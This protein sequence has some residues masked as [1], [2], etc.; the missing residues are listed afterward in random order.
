MSRPASGNPAQPDTWTWPEERWRP[1]VEKVRAGRSLKPV[2]WPRGARCAV[3]LSFDSDHETLTRRWGDG[4]PGKL[5]QGE[6]GARAAV[7]RI[8]KLLERYDVPATFF[9]PAVVAMLYPDEQRAV[10]A[11]GQEIG[12]H[13]RGRRRMGFAGGWTSTVGD[14]VVPRI[15]DGQHSHRLLEIDELGVQAQVAAAGGVEVVEP[16][17]RVGEHEAAG[18]V[19][20]AGLP[21]DLL[22]LLVD[23]QRVVLELG[24]VGVGVEGVHAAG[25]VPGGAGGELGALQQDERPV[26]RAGAPADVV[27]P[28]LSADAEQVELDGALLIERFGLKA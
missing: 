27:S 6:Y 21:G 23:L 28:V 19:D 11:G 7:P 12:I 24:D 15:H 25:G 9:V 17:L 14:D 4:S 13:S 3:A 2:A 16:V 1:L 10:V 22:D 20:A 18:K 5:S 8:L 26:P